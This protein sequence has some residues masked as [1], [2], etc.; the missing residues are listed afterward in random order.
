[1]ETLGVAAVGLT[2]NKAT[3]SQVEKLVRF[4]QQ[5]GE[6]RIVLLP[7]CDEE[8]EAG[9]REL[10]WKLTEKRVNV[11]LG[12]TSAMF[13]GQFK[14]RQPEDFGDDDWKMIDGEL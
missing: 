6:N 4:A 2:S 13:D 11:Q 12:C 10:L 9:F 1:M 3:N 5:V 14:G 7:D 8:G